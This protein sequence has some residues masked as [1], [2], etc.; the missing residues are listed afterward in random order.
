MGKFEFLHFC[1]FV[2]GRVSPLLRLGRSETRLKY[3][4]RQFLIVPP[5]QAKTAFF[6][7]MQLHSFH[8]FK[9]IGKVKKGTS[10]KITTCKSYS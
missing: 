4:S 1:L 9:R 8:I 3:L 10:D 5:R 6:S 2:I 7:F